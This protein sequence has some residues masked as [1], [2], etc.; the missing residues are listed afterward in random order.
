MQGVFHLVASPEVHSSW[1]SFAP[2]RLCVKA[3]QPISGKA[4]KAQ[5]TARKTHAI[6]RFGKIW[7]PMLVSL[8]LGCHRSAALPVAV[9]EEPPE[10]LSEYGLFL[11]NGSTQEPAEG[12]VPYDI[13]SPLFSDYALKYRFVRLPPGTSARYDSGEVFA[14]PVGTVIA[15]TFAY[16]MDLRDVSRGRQL[17]ETRLLIHKPDGWIGLPY[18]WNEEQT[19]ATLELAGGTQ[20]VSWIHTDGRRRSNNYLIPNANQCKGCHENDKVTKP[21]GPRARQLNKD[22]AYPTGTENELAHW[23]RLGLLEGAPPPEQAP[24]LAVWND[25]ATG[26]LDERARAWLEINCAH[27]HNPR[28]P[29]R[30]SGLDLRADQTGRL[31]RGL[32]K[33]PVA[34]GRGSGGRSYD[35]VPGRPDDSILVY[36]MQSTE[37]GVMMP[38]LSR[39]LVD[40][41][42]LALVRQWVASLK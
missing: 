33:T 34:A 40:E 37:P 17:V 16:A 26:S 31:P 13:N 32:W 8:A 15:K 14:F 10:R 1:R 25:P 11:G 18:V 24:R 39:R 30:T 27:C 3:W 4:A 6:A 20:D 38:E 2:W 22:F 35:I 9:D 42:G 7:L 12:V 5:R 29:A 36:R 21:I 41:E 19:E 23:T 28:G